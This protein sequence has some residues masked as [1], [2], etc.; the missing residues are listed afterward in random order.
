MASPVILTANRHYLARK[1]VVWAIKRMNPCRRLTCARDREKVRAVKKSFAKVLY[2]TWE[3][4]RKTNLTQNLHVGRCPRRNHVFQI[5]EWNLEGLRFT[6]GQIFD[7]PIDFWMVMTTVQR[8]ATALPLIF[9]VLCCVLVK[10]MPVH[11]VMLSFHN[12]FCLFVVCYLFYLTVGNLAMFYASLS[13]F[14]EST[15][16]VLLLIPTSGT[17]KQDARGGCLACRCRKE[18]FADC[19]SPLYRTNAHCTLDGET[20]KGVSSLRVVLALVVVEFSIPL[21]IL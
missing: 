14:Q 17:R 11:S 18:M 21:N 13:W 20:S 10:I 3:N 16:T 9:P 19:L 6:Q 15:C 7:F 12:H 8:Y 5:L 2:F 1:Q 4:P